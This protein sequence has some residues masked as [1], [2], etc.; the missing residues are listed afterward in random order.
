MRQRARGPGAQLAARVVGGLEHHALGGLP[1]ATDRALHV[2][3]VEHVDLDPLR[4]LPGAR[5][6]PQVVG[7]LHEHPVDGDPDVV[8]RVVADLG[9]EADQLQ[10]DLVADHLVDELGRPRGRLL[11]DDL[12][13]RASVGHDPG[14]G[15]V[16]QDSRRCPVCAPSATTWASRWPSAGDD[17]HALDASAITRS[18]IVRICSSSSTSIKPRSALPT[19]PA[20]RAAWSGSDSHLP[21]RRVTSAPATFSRT[22]SSARKFVPTNSPSPAAH[23]V[24]ARRDDRRVR[25]REPQRVAEQRRDREPVGQRADHRRLGAGLHV[26]DPALRVRPDGHDGH[27]VDQR[28]Q[29]EQTR[30]HSLHPAQA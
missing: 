29:D 21:T 15:A 25:D 17:L 6:R 9:D 3:V 19:S 10:V 14:V 12:D 16:G 5:V 27:D 4:A 28:G 2:R 8:V 7:E 18:I 22:T 26:A 24:L 23:L 13:D 1:H 20:T 11:G 30:G